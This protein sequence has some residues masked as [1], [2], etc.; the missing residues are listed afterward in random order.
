MGR[1]T[2]NLDQQIVALL[3]ELRMPAIRQSYQSE[4]Q[5]ARAETLSYERYRGCPVNC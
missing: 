4:A 1:K 5:R 3:K 2:P